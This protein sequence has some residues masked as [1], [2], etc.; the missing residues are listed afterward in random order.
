MVNKTGTFH[1]FRP[2]KA[3]VLGDFLL[4][5]Y[6]MG[7]VNRISPEAPVPVM[8]VLSE[9]AKAGGAGNAVLNL[10]ALGGFVFA[11][12]RIGSDGKGEDLKSRLNA[13]G[14]DTE[15]LF[16]EMGYTTPIKNRLIAD[17]QQLLRVD[18]EK[19]TPLSLEIEEIAL[20]R[21]QVLVPQVQVIAI[22]DY[23]KGFLSNRLI[24]AAIELGKFFKV[25]TIV[26]PKGIDFFKYRG[27]T[28]L[29]PNLFEAYLA[30]KM[31]HTEPLDAVAREIF[32]IADVKQL[33]IT[34]SEAGISLFN[35]KGER[36]DFPVQSKEVKDV[37]GAGD[38]VLA[39]MSL[40]LAN[41]LDLSLVVQLA[42]IAAGLSIERL[43]CAQI[44]LAEIAERFLEVDSDSK[45]FQQ[46]HMY[47]LHQVLGN[48][49][50][51]LL[52]LEKKEGMSSAVFKMIRH[53][54]EL[55]DKELVIYVKDAQPEDEFIHLLASL[56]EVKT[57]IVQTENLKSLCD[58]IHPDQVYFVE[59]KEI[60][61]AKEL[62][63]TL[64]TTLALPS[65]KNKV[66]KG[67]QSFGG[68][69]G[70]EP[71]FLSSQE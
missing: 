62:L 19:I 68:V 12:G 66:S 33:L 61:Q 46:N 35:P 1:Q 43:G 26:D 32:K 21:L 47:A 24:Q 15:S 8:E 10:I 2:F 36:K 58:A 53:L 49:S 29:K 37:T 22:S 31:A 5:T 34:R 4:D 63:V 67:C 18:F 38:T 25:P 51:C 41:R 27:A 3:L 52:V 39:V 60:K 44:T 70:A 6:L 50:Y 30:A 54:G 57:I 9:E 11:M 20:K 28:L 56:H 17:G 14:A 13:K 42:N 64:Y 40:G 23:G 7:K 65:E 71:H 59:G 16:V 69:N 48:K 55:P 45:I